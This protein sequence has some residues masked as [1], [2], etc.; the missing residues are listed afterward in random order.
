MPTDAI[1]CMK[2]NHSGELLA[3]GDKG[4]LI[5]VLRRQQSVRGIE[6]VHGLYLVNKIFYIYNL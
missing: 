6:S 4:G 5:S 3:V 2:F 1:S